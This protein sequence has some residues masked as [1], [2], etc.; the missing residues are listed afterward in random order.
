MAKMG[1]PIK[2]DMDD[3]EVKKQVQLFGRLCAT[4]EEMKD[5]FGV[6]LSTIEK[7]MRDHENEEDNSNFLRVYKKASSET[8]ASLRRRQMKLAEDGNATMLIWLG[9]QLLKQKD[10]IETEH[11]GAISFFSPDMG[12]KKIEDTV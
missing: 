8:K 9:K 4:H 5:W 2:I 7:L 12:D 11:T 3:P 6:C 10:Q 1:A